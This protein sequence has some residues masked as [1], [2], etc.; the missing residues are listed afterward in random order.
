[1]RRVLA[2][3]LVGLAAVTGYGALDAY[4]VVPGVVTLAPPATP[5]VAPPTASSGIPTVRV[6]AL[7]SS[8]MPLAPAGAV[9]SAPSAAG[10]QAALA[11]VLADRSLAGA[12]VT[13]RDGATGAHLLDVAADQPRVPASTTKLLSAVGIDAALPATTT[14]ATTVVQGASPDRVV[15]VAG[16]DSLLAPVAGD[17]TAV[18]G[19]AGLGDLADQ[20]A[21]A[22][23]AS[24]VTTVTVGVDAAYA[25]GPLVAPT[26]P[27]SFATSGITGRV[28]MLGLASKRALPGTPGSADPIADTAAAF[29]ARLGERG[30]AATYDPAATTAPAGAAVLGTVQSAPV[31]ALLALALDESDNALTECLARQAAFR[32][33]RPSDFAGTAAYLIDSVRV[34]GVDVTGV[35][36]ADASGLTRANQVPARV[37]GDVLALAVGGSRPGLAAA[38]ARLPVA[39]LSGTLAGRFTAPAS[40]PGAGVVR[41]KT[42]TLNGVNTLAGTVVTADGRLL[43]FAVL[44]QGSAATLDVRAALDRVGATLATCG[45]R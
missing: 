24:G 33:G 27:E 13:V 34:A 42:G 36:L 45:C 4:D 41:A 21:T 30:I 1:M 35:Q 28:A 12:S 9:G 26:W 39:G 31:G 10:V 38:I 3:V 23:R 16:G 11:P 32:A 15:L 18:A 22:L 37:L 6:P 7:P 8:G 43:L 40:T 17:P 14:L 44:E 25:P 5:T 20:V 19:R 2:V 29:V